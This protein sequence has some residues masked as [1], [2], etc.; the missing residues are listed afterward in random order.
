MSVLVTMST[1][2]S[3]STSSCSPSPEEPLIRSRAPS[4]S[5]R[6]GVSIG[7]GEEQDPICSGITY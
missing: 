3:F 4:T 6:F 7:F 1:A 5:Q 2:F